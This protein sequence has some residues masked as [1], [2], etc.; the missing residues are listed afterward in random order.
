[1]I[2]KKNTST[3]YIEVF[4]NTIGNEN[5]FSIVS[6]YVQYAQLIN[7][8]V[9]VHHANKLLFIII[10]TVGNTNRCRLAIGPKH[11]IILRIL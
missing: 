6:F 3:L 4:A 7:S 1:M 2:R 8:A 9:A 5:E 10:R 11:S